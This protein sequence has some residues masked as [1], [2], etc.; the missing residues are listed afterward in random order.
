MYRPAKLHRL[1]ESIPGLIKSLENRHRARTCKRLRSPGIDSK[2]SVAPTYV[3]WRA[4]TS[5]K[6]VAPAR[7]SGNRFLCS[8]TDLQI[9]ALDS[10]GARAVIVQYC[11]VR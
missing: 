11:K 4:G 1:T 9:R 8:L 3:A 7:L 10:M 5:N 2:E 6:V